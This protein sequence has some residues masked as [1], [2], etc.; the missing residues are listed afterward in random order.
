MDKHVFV[1][2]VYTV[3]VYSQAE[4]DRRRARTAEAFVSVVSISHPLASHTLQI[5][6]R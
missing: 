3:R 4:G 2:D 6:K 1:K 5:T